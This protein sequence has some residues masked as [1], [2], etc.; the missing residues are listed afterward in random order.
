MVST[1]LMSFL[2]NSKENTHTHKKNP[3]INSGSIN[4]ECIHVN[5]QSLCSSDLKAI[6]TQALEEV[7]CVTEEWQRDP[8]QCR[9]RAG[10][11]FLQPHRPLLLG[12]LE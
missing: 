6:V 12:S 7:F 4:M 5:Q 11:H 1:R 8:R 2:A 3:H 9:A 10:R